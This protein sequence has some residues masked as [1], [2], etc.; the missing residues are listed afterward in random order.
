MKHKSC[1]VIIF[2]LGLALMAGCATTGENGPPIV[3]DEQFQDALIQITARNLAFFVGRNNPAI[4][5]PAIAFC[6]AFAGAQAV[7]LEP[8][9]AQGLTYLDMEVKDYPLAKKDL[10]TLLILFNIQILN[11]DIPLT[12]RQVVMVKLAAASM[13]DGFEMAKQNPKEVK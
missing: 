12:P 9:I 3:Q 10:E 7:D 2:V 11:A 13:K 4:L 5:D 1:L 6:A 8:L